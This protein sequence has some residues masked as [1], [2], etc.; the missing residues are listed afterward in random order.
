MYKNLEAWEHCLDTLRDPYL[1]SAFG[2]WLW[3]Y[4]LV[5]LWAFLIGQH[6]WIGA[7]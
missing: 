7:F 2:V 3:K 6:I 4:L 1:I 5:T